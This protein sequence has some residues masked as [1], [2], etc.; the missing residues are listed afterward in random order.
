[1]IASRRMAFA[2]LFAQGS[3][4]P[5]S[6]G[7][8]VFPLPMR[9]SQLQCYQ[10]RLVLISLTVQWYEPRV[11]DFSMLLNTVAELCWTLLK[12][13]E[14]CWTLLNFA[15]VCWVLLNYYTQLT[16]VFWILLN[17]ADFCWSLLNSAELC[18]TLLS[19]Q[20][21]ADIKNFTE[22]KVIIFTDI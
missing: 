7:F 8:F 10:V 14:L 22:F 13:A 21:S 11:A 5:S 9:S 3:T 12:F 6:R 16:R 20:V 19:Q 15:E 4:S 1:M 17:F 18:W 2:S